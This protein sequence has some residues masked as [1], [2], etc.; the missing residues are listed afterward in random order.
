MGSMLA[1]ALGIF[2]TIVVFLIFRSVML[3]YWRLDDLADNVEKILV[4]IKKLNPQYRYCS[5][6]K[7]F[8]FSDA[9]IC[10]HCKAP[11]DIIPK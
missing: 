6:C 5:N 7:K 9:A 2:G 1:L 8:N 11:L 3:W 10:G 4:E